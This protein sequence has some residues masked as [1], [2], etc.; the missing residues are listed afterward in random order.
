MV[1]HKIIMGFFLGN[2]Q[3]PAC[4]QTSAWFYVIFRTGTVSVGTWDL[5]TSWRTC[6]DE[7]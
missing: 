5:I 3:S 1:S 6:G 4:S 7:I 2:L